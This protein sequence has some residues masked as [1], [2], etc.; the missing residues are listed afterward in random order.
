M[1]ME[2]GPSGAAESLMER[3]QVES[4]APADLVRNLTAASA[5]DAHQ[6]ELNTP[7]KASD[8]GLSFRRLGGFL[9][10]SIE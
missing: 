7:S 3:G 4:V 2:A 8:E 6:E 1:A 9:P 5:V 10:R